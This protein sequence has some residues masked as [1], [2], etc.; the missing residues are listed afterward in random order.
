[1]FQSSRKYPQS[2]IDRSHTNQSRFER[3]NRHGLSQ[4]N[5]G[6][7]THIYSFPCRRDICT[8][9][10]EPCGTLGESRL[11]YS[12]IDIHIYH[13]MYFTHINV[14]SNVGKYVK[15]RCLRRRFQLC[16]RFISAQG[17]HRLSGGMSFRKFSRS[18]EAASLNFSN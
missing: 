18:L 2:I 10:N 3:Y 12:P 1:M 17:L 14:H 15:Y 9:K 4:A 5:I 16:P 11:Q 7:F 6:F 8:Y 13:G